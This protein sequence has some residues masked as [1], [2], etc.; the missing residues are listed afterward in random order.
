MNADGTTA[1]HSWGTSSASTF[2]PMSARPLVFAR[3]SAAALAA[4]AAGG[5][6][7]SNA[8]VVTNSAST[9][10]T[11]RAKAGRVGRRAAR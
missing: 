6:V 3:P 4:L 5:A 1:G 10:S 7:Q 2:E 9:S 11:S 8:A